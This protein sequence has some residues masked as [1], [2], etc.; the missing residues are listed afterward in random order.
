MSATLAAMRPILR[1]VPA[2]LC[3]V[4]SVLL[5][6]CIPT[7]T[8]GLGEV[9]DGSDSAA[10][11]RSA[12]AFPDIG[13]VPAELVV[14]GLAFDFTD[15]PRDQD[16]WTPR[17]DEAQ[18]AAEQIVSSIGAERIVALG[19]RPGVGGASLNDVDL[20]EAEQAQVA[21]AVT[22]C[23]DMTEAFAAM[24]YGAGRIDAG[25]ATCVAR[26]MGDAQMLTPIVDA[27]VAG[28][29][30]DPFGDDGSF[31]RALAGNAEVCIASDTFLWPH[32]HVTDDEGILDSDAEAGSI[33]SRYAD[34]ARRATTSTVDT[35]VPDQP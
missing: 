2:V 29:A 20:T 1:R 33:R 31:A 19:Y 30:I 12:P 16:Y 10:S 27:W 34:D 35:L 13:N 11:Q 15:R 6:A 5:A 7:D 24:L 26:G 18:C 32:L 23:V 28:A 25:V 17:S 22:E 21:D 3:V 14:E 8:E 4:A 9:D